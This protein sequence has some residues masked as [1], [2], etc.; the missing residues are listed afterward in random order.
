M[1]FKSYLVEKNIN[2]LEKDLVL[3]YGENLG[4]INE[5]KNIIRQGNLQK[6]IILLNQDEIL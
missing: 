2:S 4:L 6:E 3:F 5:F 1:I